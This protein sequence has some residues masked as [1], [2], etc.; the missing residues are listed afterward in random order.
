MKLLLILQM[1][2]ALFVLFINPDLCY[3]IVHYLKQI[4]T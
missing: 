1:V 3:D 4:L 2:L